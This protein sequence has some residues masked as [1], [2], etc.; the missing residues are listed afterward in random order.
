MAAVPPPSHPVSAMPPVEVSRPPL[1]K[2]TS[3]GT[4]Q[5]R[6]LSLHKEEQTPRITRER[7]SSTP[8]DDGRIDPRKI[9]SN[10][11]PGSK[12]TSPREATSPR[13]N[14]SERRTLRNYE[15]YK[16]R[17]GA[18]LSPSPRRP[19]DTPSP[20][21]HG[22]NNSLQN[23]LSDVHEAPKP[24]L[25][26]RSATNHYSFGTFRKLNLDN[27][28]QFI[29]PPTTPAKSKLDEFME[30]AVLTKTDQSIEENVRKLKAESS[31]SSEQVI[32]RLEKICSRIHSPRIYINAGDF[33]IGYIQLCLPSEIFSS[34]EI[35][36]KII[37]HLNEIN[38]DTI[39]QQI[40]NVSCLLTNIKK[41]CFAD[42]FIRLLGDKKGD[43][44]FGVFCSNIL[45]AYEWYTT[46]KLLFEYAFK[47]ITSFSNDEKFYPFIITILNFIVA[48]LDQLSFT[49]L[50]EHCR[51]LIRKFIQYCAQHDDI[52]INLSG[53][54]IEDLF[55]EKLLYEMVA[56]HALSTR[57]ENCVPKL[58]AILQWKEIRERILQGE[59]DHQD[60][61]QVLKDIIEE[62]AAVFKRIPS[63]ELVKAR[64]ST[65]QCIH[66]PNIKE[67]IVFFNSFSNFCSSHILK[68]DSR[69]KAAHMI[70]F[71]IFLADQCLNDIDFANLENMDVSNLFFDFNVAYSIFA[72]LE[73]VPVSRLKATFRSLSKDCLLKHAKLIHLFDSADNYKILR[74]TCKSIESRYIEGVKVVPV[75]PMLLKDILFIDQGNPDL[76]KGKI[77]EGKMMMLGESLSNFTRYQQRL[78]IIREIRTDIFRAIHENFV[79]EETLYELSHKLEPSENKH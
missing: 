24:K 43:E 42:L 49:S 41:E 58:K 32:S 39:K 57:S 74:E 16:T 18:T 75:M 56:K 64:W 11:D 3:G 77:N 50:D 69:V 23:I 22:L 27:L 60:L 36:Q 48:A 12:P 5:G 72:S 62:D 78:P 34:R 6:K 52:N 45:T 21:S 4:L 70:H 46:T 19:P 25:L 65:N 79:P 8:R 71:F 30:L 68:C 47:T 2:Q 10:Q 53:R 28:P 9:S 29:S 38:N 17:A 13:E 14:E 59:I 26:S 33:I 61:L 55:E 67:H 54:T 40:K 37:M 20:R 51:Q 73:S 15:E 1:Q 31:I 44:P 63:S 66:T 76:I 7:P 35:L